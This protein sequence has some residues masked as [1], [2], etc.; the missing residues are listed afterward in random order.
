VAAKLRVDQSTVHDW[1]CGDISNINSDN[2]YI[3][4]PPDLRTP[5]PERDQRKDFTPCEAVAIGRRLTVGRSPT[6]RKV[7]S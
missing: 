6:S 3:P 4:K 5:P 7:K 2:A 1:E